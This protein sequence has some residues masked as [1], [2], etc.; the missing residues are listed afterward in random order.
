MN[1]TELFVRRPVLATVVNLVL[2]LIGVVAFNRLTV[3]E[4]PNIDVPTVTV[5]TDY[6][7]AP[8]SVVET[9]IT[10]P[11]EDQ[12]SGIEGIDYMTSISRAEQSQITV[13]FRLTRDA[14]QAASDVRDKVS[15]AL[16]TL[17]DEADAP[18]VAKT[19]ADA[20]P[21]IWLAL[22]STK[23]DL[24]VVSDYAARTVKDR[25]QTLPG[26][27]SVRIFGERKPSMRI[28]LD[29]EKM[30]ARRVTTQDVENA[31]SAQ[32][33]DIPAGRV[34]ST[35]REFTVR[36][37]TDT[38]TPEQFRN[39][40]VSKQGDSLVRI[41]DVAR[42]EIAPEDE[43]SFTRFNGINSIGIGIIKQSTANPVEVSAALQKVLPDIQANMPDGMKIQVAYDS[44]IFIKSAIHAVYKT[45]T[46]AVVLVAIVIFLFLGSF[47]ATL[48]P[49]I[50]IPI[51]LIGSF[52]MISAMG[53][54][55][56]TLT[57]LALV[58]AIGLVVDDAIVVLENIFR[59]M[60]E[61]M[62][63]FAAAIRGI[64]EIAFAVIAMTLT[65]A[66]VFAPLAFST[67][68]TGKLFTEFALTLAGTVLISGFIAL[69]L[70][71]MMCS[72]LLRTREGGTTEK[73]RGWIDHTFAK[74]SNGYKER[75]EW[76]LEKRGLV[77]FVAAVVALGMGVLFWAL[78]SELSPTE[79][80]GVFF[81]V[82]MA[83]EGSTPEYLDK[84]ARQA[85]AVLDSIPQESWRFIAV[86]FPISTQAFSAIG[87]KPWDERS[88]SQMSV[89]QGIFPKLFGIPGI[90]AFAINPPSLGARFTSKPLEL[91]IQTNGTYADL[92]NIVEEVMKR[93]GENTN[94]INLD[95]DLKLNKPEL[96][97]ALQRDK[98]ADMGVGVD[99]LGRTLETT[100]G[101]RQ[102]TRYKDG[103]EQYDVMVQ[104][105]RDKR[106]EPT[107]I[108]GIAVRAANGQMVQLGN[109]V[110]LHE[111]VAPR[112]L[113]HFNKLRAATISASLKPGY[114]LGDALQYMQKLVKDV[115]K[116]K[117][118]IEYGGQTRE[119]IESGSAMLAM[120][121]L[122]LVFIF[123]VLAAQFESFV[124]P[125]TIM[126]AV[127]LAMFGAMF[128][129]RIT[130]GT[131]NV[132]SQIGLL[133]LVGLIT[134]H[135]I[136]LVE[137]A[138]V[139]RE[140]GKDVFEAIKNA[141]MLRLRPILM[142]TAATVLGAVPLALAH[143]AGAESR[144][145]IGWVIVGGMTVGTLLTLFVI[146][147]IYTLLARYASVH[148]DDDVAPAP[149]VNKKG[150][151]A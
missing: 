49:V 91:V 31:L 84:Y 151:K 3:R 6:R 41:G 29:P 93:A 8:A 53:F 127:P 98:M 113:N 5:Q 18:V 2:V 144:Q 14:D 131:M 60:E 99:T 95:S 48:I 104:V 39:I 65:L 33:V 118:Q 43:R 125:V 64:K 25:L 54:S 109:L 52:A 23:K 147:T 121:G 94:L 96:R 46:E 105:A 88:V 76:S 22:S 142:T 117:V 87:L 129:L 138:N 32:N 45:I 137:F 80:R 79:D 9:Q 101:G 135:G 140:E 66:A 12:I 42:V 106:A 63:P 110:D 108:D 11:L 107:D 55:I 15:R 97:V 57:L 86:G 75:L 123:L 100:L 92:N 78:P 37:E 148:H 85:E 72:K 146:P 28:W 114:A 77:L 36:S 136:M 24:M 13:A 21:I 20:Q 115:G 56:N 10:K 141:C 44:S 73:L 58:L 132:Y 4:Y 102:V 111:G 62:K 7:G 112:E 128:T 133:T 67:G 47:R 34:E 59:H 90:M 126:L 130:G 19:E 70:S 103:G 50:T 143:G 139:Q 61:G 145:Q 74:I 119:Y 150:R 81:T 122:A 27:S 1:L 71:P 40:V 89:V 68:Q 149:A 26:V 83:P 134:K 16:Q 30:A 35:Y 120:F 69:T 17:P 116:D 124:T 51:S 82:M 38:N